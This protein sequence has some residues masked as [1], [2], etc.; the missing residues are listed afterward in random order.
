MRLRLSINDKDCAFN[1]I[2]PKVKYIISDL[3]D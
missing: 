1:D 3:D 2:D